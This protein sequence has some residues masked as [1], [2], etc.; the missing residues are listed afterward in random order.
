[1]PAQEIINKYKNKVLNN[2]ALT[3][4]EAQALYCVNDKSCLNYL[5]SAAYEI[6]S[7]FLKDKVQLC[8]I[9]NARCGACSENCAFCAQSSFH[10]T[11]VRAYPLLSIRQVYRRAERAKEIG[12][13]FFC[14]VTSGRKIA[15]GKDFL[16]ICG[17]IKKIT[18]NFKIKVDASLGGLSLEQARLLKEAGLFRY[19]HNLETSASFYPKVCTTHTYSDRLQTIDNVRKAGLELCCGGIFGMGEDIRQRLELLFSLREINPECIPINFLNPVSGTRLGSQK[20]T[21]ALEFL[22]IVALCRFL[23]PRQE[24]KICGG[25][26]VNLRSLQPFLFLAGANSIIIGDYLTTKGNSPRY[27]LQMIRDLGLKIG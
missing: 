14:I 23:F 17:M 8:A 16:K 1:M 10:N 7:K 20:Q 24:I 12:A 26:E 3:R 11:K 15:S 27:D 2:K 18:A 6:R 21:G 5:F 25:R 19:N 22:K 9:T 13:G 4:K